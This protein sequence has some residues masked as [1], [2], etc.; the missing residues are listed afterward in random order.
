MRHHGA[1]P[2]SRE[3]EHVVGLCDETLPALQLDGREGASGGHQRPPVAP[4]QHVGGHRLRAGCGVGEH[5]DHG[6]GGARGHLADR[7]LGEE[8]GPAAGAHQHGGGHLADHHLQVAGGAGFEPEPRQLLAGKR[9][10]EL[11]VLDPVAPLEDQTVRVDHDHRVPHGLLGRTRVPHCRLEQ[12]GDADARGA[13]SD[14]QRP[15]VTQR[16]PGLAQRRQDAPQHHRGGSLHVVVEAGYPFPVPIQEPDRVVLLEVLPLQQRMRKDVPHRLHESLDEAVVGGASQP[17]LGVAEVERIAQEMG[18]V[19]PAV[20]RHGQR[21]GGTDSGSGG[22]EGQLADGDAHAPR[23]LVAEAEDALVVGGHDQT[24]VRPAC[25]AQQLWDAID[26]IGG[27]PQPL[28]A[29]Q[30]VAEGPARVAHRGRVD[31]RRQLLEMIDEHAVKEGLVAIVERGQADVALQVVPL[32]SEVLELER[33]LLG[34]GQRSPGEQPAQAVVGSLL[35][36]EGGVLVELRVGQQ[37]MPA[38]RIG[39]GRVLGWRRSVQGRNHARDPPWAVGGGALRRA[40]TLPSRPRSGHGRMAQIPEAV[41]RTAARRKEG[42]VDIRQRPLEQREGFGIPE[43]CRPFGYS[44]A[45][46]DVLAT[47]ARHRRPA[48]GR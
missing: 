24:D 13:G 41:R 47:L 9:E 32:A 21:E 18:V 16:P 35:L 1:E 40:P 5:Q 28:R 17:R 38:G 20:Q 15:L 37:P 29:P 4:G 33:H 34:D 44:G 42:A 12:P 2:D 31:D 7:G 26:V 19:G 11:V 6:A 46:I 8:A 10:G 23:A 45:P 25:V 3:D 48:A 27:D 39:G 30:H 14:E 22:V 36:G 43:G